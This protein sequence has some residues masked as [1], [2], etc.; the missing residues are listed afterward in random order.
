MSMN[1]EFN[2][3]IYALIQ[4][5]FKHNKILTYDFSEAMNDSKQMRSSTEFTPVLK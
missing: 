5:W 3:W 1:G 4:G 2:G